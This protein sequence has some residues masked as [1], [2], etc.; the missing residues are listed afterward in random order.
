MDIP[1]SLVR[2]MALFRKRG[3]VENYTMGLFLE[4]SWIAVY[5]GQGI[6][7]DGWDQRIDAIPLPQLNA[8]LDRL[9]IEIDVAAR[10]MPDHREAIAARG[11]AI[12]A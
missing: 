7:P 6:L 10:A 1:D 11:A 12:A 2:K 4:V 9:R 5:L 3:R 8:A